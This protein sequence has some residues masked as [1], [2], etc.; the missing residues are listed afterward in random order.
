MVD[1]GMLKYSIQKETFLAI[2]S[3]TRKGIDSLL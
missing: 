2:T 1:T 3:L